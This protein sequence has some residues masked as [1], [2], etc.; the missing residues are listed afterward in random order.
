MTPK[1][2][3]EA[4]IEEV[5]G[6]DVESVYVR[7]ELQGVLKSLTQKYSYYMYRFTSSASVSKWEFIKYKKQAHP[8]TDPDTYE[9]IKDWILEQPE[10]GWYEY[11]ESRSIEINE[12]TKEYFQLHSGF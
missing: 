3:L 2:A 12:C 11:A 7:S 9:M 5:Q 4:A 1:Q 8:L 10:N 6:T